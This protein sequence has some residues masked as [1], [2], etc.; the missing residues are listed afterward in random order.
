M[1]P[2]SSRGSSS[3]GRRRA[4]GCP[5]L[6]ALQEGP[7]GGCGCPFLY[8]DEVIRRPSRGA[9]FFFRRLVPARRP[10]TRRY[11]AKL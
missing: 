10:H 4:R 7:V 11:A 5:C 6:V 2:S 9:I 8:S 3:G 1:G